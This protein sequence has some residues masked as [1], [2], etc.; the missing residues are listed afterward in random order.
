MDSQKIHRENGLGT[1][2]REFC[3]SL[4]EIELGREVSVCCALRLE[5]PI[6]LVVALGAGYR[7]EPV[8]NK[9]Q[10]GTQ[11]LFGSA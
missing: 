10:D 4:L 6:G 2:C 5:H 8:S 9:R 7:F 1:N 11:T 3:E